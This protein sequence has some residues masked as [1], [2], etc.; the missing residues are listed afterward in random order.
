MCAAHGSPPP[1][2]APLFPRRCRQP[3]PV[4]STAL[5]APA[6]PGTCGA[7]TARPARYDQVDLDGEPPPGPGDRQ[8]RRAV[9]HLAHALGV[10]VAD[11]RA[12]R[13]PTV[14]LELWSRR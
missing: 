10:G 14:P 7:A 8:P 12:W 2:A 5:P 6:S 3:G 13:A 11:D 4:D 1:Q 9:R